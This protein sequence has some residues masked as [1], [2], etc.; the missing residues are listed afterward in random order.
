MYCHFFFLGSL[1]HNFIYLHMAS[2]THC[3]HALTSKQIVC[4]TLLG[5]FFFLYIHW[6]FSVKLQ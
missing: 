6:E 2:V 1:L 5:F 4:V 3:G